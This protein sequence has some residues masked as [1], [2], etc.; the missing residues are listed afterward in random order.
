M[1]N[2]GIQN[3]QFKYQFR[4]LVYYSMPPSILFVVKKR[5]NFILLCITFFS[6]L[7]F[8]LV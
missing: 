6:F 5:F 2:S 4:N 7:L 1:L 8:T 3:L